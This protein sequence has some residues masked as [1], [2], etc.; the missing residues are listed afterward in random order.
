[1]G[2]TAPV[3]ATSPPRRGTSPAAV[4]YDLTPRRGPLN[5]RRGKEATEK[6]G[7]ASQRA[8]APPE[9]DMYA[10][11]RVGGAS[12]RHQKEPRAALCTAVSLGKSLCKSQ[13][14]PQAALSMGVSL[15]K[16][17]ERLSGEASQR[18][19]RARPRAPRAASRFHPNE[20][21][22]PPSPPPATT[23]RLEGCGADTEAGRLRKAATRC[24]G[25]GRRPLNSS[26]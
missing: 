8:K 16:S 1:M 19:P 11:R 26:G 13:K 14:E 6:G 15:F 24:C 7:K 23:A 4:R 17:L 18:H 2:R 25:L 10:R 21:R 9:T 3:A 20:I 12:E 5:R 22:P